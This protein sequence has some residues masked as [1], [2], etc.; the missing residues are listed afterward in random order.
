MKR[1]ALLA[2]IIL[3]TIT[4]VAVVWQLH[5]VLLILVLSLAIAAML[6]QPVETLVQNGWKRSLAI[7]AVYLSGFGLLIAVSAGV[8]YFM[9]QEIDPLMQDLVR[10]YGAVQA[11]LVGLANPG[12]AWAARLPSTAELARWW[13]VDQGAVI[14][15]Q[16]TEFLQHAGQSVTEFVLSIFLSLYWTVDRNRFERLWFSL[17]SA[18]TR[19]RTRR[20]WRRLE[21]DVGAYM[22]SE[23]LQTIVAIVVFAAGYMLLGIKY[24][25]TLAVIAGVAWLVPL[26]GGVLALLPVVIIGLLTGPV[27]AALASAYTVVVLVVLEFYV[28]PKFYVGGRYW[29]VLLV[30]IMLAMADAFGLLGLIL[31]PP[32]ALAVQIALDEILNTQ[33]PAAVSVQSMDLVALRRRLDEVRAR[34][35]QEGPNASPRLLNLVQRLET[36]IADIE[37]SGVSV[38]ATRSQNEPVMAGKLPLDLAENHA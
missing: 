25:V 35:D 23:I 33:A 17:L 10:V 30:V 6:G 27:T 38:E 29:G 2:A 7:A 18:E 13:A 1:I 9:A 34:I 24:P 32:I 15:Q 22:R 36:L 14:L 5:S 21:S 37:K 19:T 28:Q 4:L 3:L 31:A 12:T 8:V 11:M 20:V 16:T 26:L